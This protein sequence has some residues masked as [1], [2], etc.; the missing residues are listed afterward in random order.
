MVLPSEF[1]VYLNSHEVLLHFLLGFSDLLIGLEDLFDKLGQSLGHRG[2]NLVPLSSF[3]DQAPQIAIV[4]P[5]ICKVPDGELVGQLPQDDEEGLN[6][7]A[8]LLLV[9]V[10]HSQLKEVDLLVESGVEYFTMLK[11]GGADFYLGYRMRPLGPYFGG[12]FTL[13]VRIS[14]VAHR[15]P[16]E[17]CV[18]HYKIISFYHIR[19]ILME[20]KY[21]CRCENLDKQE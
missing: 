16:L 19:K 8:L 15:V 11:L 2:D 7:R 6:L 20:A 17:E 4:S 9:K 13:E 1:E 10:S 21:G 5:E 14:P 3:G 18:S 12:P